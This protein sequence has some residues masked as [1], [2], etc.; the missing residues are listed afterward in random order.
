MEKYESD[1]IRAEARIEAAEDRCKEN[2]FLTEAIDSL[3]KGLIV[4]N[5]VAD[6]VAQVKSILEKRR[7]DYADNA[8]IDREAGTVGDPFN[9]DESGEDSN[10]TYNFSIR[11]EKFEKSLAEDKR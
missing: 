9:T 8:A 10:S 3:E 5:E 4:K 2:K 1:K 11:L 7:R 6:L